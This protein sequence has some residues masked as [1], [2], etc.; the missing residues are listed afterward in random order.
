MTYMLQ[1][2]YLLFREL[3]FA[4]DFPQLIKF[5]LVLL[6]VPPCGKKFFVYLANDDC[7]RC[8]SVRAFV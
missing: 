3:C 1:A 7:I 8:A 6:Q 5:H 4:I 2:L